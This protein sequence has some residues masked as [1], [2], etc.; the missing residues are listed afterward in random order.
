MPPRRLG[1]HVTRRTR[2]TPAKSEISENTKNLIVTH[3][4]CL[5][6]FFF[7]P[8]SFSD[9][10]F[11][12]DKN[13]VRIQNFFGPKYFFWTHNFFYTKFFWIHNFI[14]TVFTKSCFQTQNFLPQNCPSCWAT[15]Q[16]IPCFFSYES[17]P[18]RDSFKKKK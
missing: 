4:R 17:F 3:R 13:L 10:T 7:Y 11:F 12:L 16:T 15:N 9:P 5:P 1:T 8:N 14:L 6:K 2:R 18:N